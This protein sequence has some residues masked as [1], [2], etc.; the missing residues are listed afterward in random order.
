M[1]D[2]INDYID[3][4]CQSVAASTVGR[5]MDLLS[6]VCNL[7]I[8]TWRIPVQGGLSPMK[9]VRRPKY[10][11][12]RDRRLRS[13]EEAKLLALAYE[14]DRK[15]CIE[16]RL[17]KLMEQERQSASNAKTTYKRKN[18]IK[19]ARTRLESEAAESYEHVAT[20]E[21]F[22]LFQLMT[23]ARLSE[24]M[25][26]LWKHVDFEAKSAFLPETKNDRPRKLP[27]RADLI[28]LFDLA[29]VSRIP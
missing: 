8:N 9:G 11:N 29:R 23:A 19:E 12:E 5:E 16:A 7:A 25:N 14:E 10:F 27:L 6:S 15:N 22:V 3:E 28:E 18:I 21:T 4:R 20:L 24:G 1:P 17:E 13:G 26:L 2:D